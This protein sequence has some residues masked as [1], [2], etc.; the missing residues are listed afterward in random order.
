MVDLCCDE[1][2]HDGPCTRPGS[3]KRKR[4]DA[5]LASTASSYA[6]AICGAASPQSEAERT[7]PR[8]IKRLVHDVTHHLCTYAYL[9]SL[10]RETLDDV[11]RHAVHFMWRYVYATRT[12]GANV[13]SAQVH[14]SLRWQQWRCQAAA[15]ICL[16]Y[17]TVH[18]TTAGRTDACRILEACL[19]SDELDALERAPVLDP[20]WAAYK[21]AEGQ[22][23]CALFALPHALGIGFLAC[24]RGTSAEQG[25]LRTRCATRIAKAAARMRRA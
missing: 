24:V 15:C 13:T 4:C 1:D 5:P 25:V 23:L 6:A 2:L 19:Y 17:K 11:R 9:A 14:A 20:V 18:D 3:N 7:A 10:R 21:A 8:S 16:A 12:S 22:V